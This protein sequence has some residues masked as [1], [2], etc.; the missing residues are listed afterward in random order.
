MSTLSRR[1]EVAVHPFNLVGVDVR[2]DLNRGWEVEN[3]PFR[4]GAPCCGDRITNLKGEIKFGGG[5]E[6]RLY[7]SVT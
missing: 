1:C 5:E 6:F 4:R 3:N 2:G 7:S